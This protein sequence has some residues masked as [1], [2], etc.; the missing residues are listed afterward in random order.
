M[1]RVTFFRQRQIWM[2]TTYGWIFLLL[3]VVVT[4]ILLVINLY[5]FL[6][7]SEP[8][9][10]RVLVVEG[11]LDSWEL[12]QAIEAFKKGKYERVVT[13]GGRASGLG[14]SPDANY[15]DL[16]AEYLKNHG[17]SSDLIDIY[18]IELPAENL[19]PEPAK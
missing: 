15:A 12:D 11:W 3:I 19:R 4:S 18:Q 7:P 9:G 13:T 5:A 10:A 17:V 16:A 14:V 2:P 8:V 6:A 1:A